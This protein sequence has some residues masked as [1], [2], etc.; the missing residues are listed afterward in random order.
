[1]STQRWLTLSALLATA[2]LAACIGTGTLGTPCGRGACPEPGD[3]GSAQGGD[4][5]PQGSDTAPLW[6]DA[7]A[8]GDTLAPSDGPA[9]A[10]IEIQ[11]ADASVAQGLSKGMTALRHEIDGSTS[12]V[13]ESCAWASSAPGTI[14]VGAAADPQPMQ[15][16]LPGVAT[17]TAT[18]GGLSGFTALTCVGIES[19]A[20]TPVSANLPQASSLQLAATADYGGSWTEDVTTIVTWSSSDTSKAAVDSGGEVTGIA[21]GVA[22]ITA[23]W[24]G[25][26][27]ASSITVTGGSSLTIDTTSPLATGTVGVAYSGPSFI[28]SGGSLPYTWSTTTGTLPAGLTLGGTGVISGT[29]TTPGIASFTV[30]VTDST[31]ANVS[32]SMS[33]E[34]FSASAT[35]TYYVSAAGS[36][37]WDGRTSSTPWA[38]LARVNSS[39]SSFVPADFIAFRRGDTFSGTLTLGKSGSDGLQ[40][41]F[42]AYGTGTNPVIDAGNVNARCI[43]TTARSYITIDGIDCRNAT[44]YG[45]GASSSPGSHIT[46]QNL[47]ISAI[48]TDNNERVGIYGI[49]GY[50]IIRNC[51]ITDISQNAIQFKG[52]HNLIVHNNISY[53][54]ARYTGWGAGI[55][56]DG[57]GDEL[58]YNVI[59]HCGGSGEINKTHGIYVQLTNAS[60][61]HNTITNSNRGAAIKTRGGGD[62]HHNYL[63]T[64]FRSGM[65]MGGNGA[66][67]VVLN[68]YSNIFTGNR[69]GI[70]VSEQD[71]G[72]FTV[73]VY[74][75]TFYRNDNTAADPYYSE[76][77]LNAD[78]NTSLVVKNNVF[79]GAGRYT[80]AFTVATT[81]T[82]IDYNCVYQPSG[83]LI[84]Y[85][86]SAITWAAWR[87]YGFDTNGFNVN[88]LFV[89]APA[90]LQLQPTSTCIDHG[91][92]MG[93]TEDYAGNPIDEFPDIGA[94]E[95]IPQ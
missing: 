8:D 2:T 43:S 92:D 86:G 85:G 17:I 48:G 18:C 75:N 46:I 35:P 25:E 16:I 42:G 45:I 50:S 93:L 15:G 1:M 33:L 32:K 21:A 80:Y 82:V 90:D 55:G 79:Y 91:V 88:P 19:L 28:A 66:I 87:G 3:T 36:D 26:Q 47:T 95:F 89:G 20:V 61:H 78:A 23:D 37:G 29:P 44:E 39:M 9:V 34:V 12:S 84:Y 57:D 65:E 67:V 62:F 73:N 53:T 60:V 41:T 74:N 24:L 30:K 72:A 22:T 69:E 7:A 59:D 54:N 56:G 58:A 6:G 51:T 64:S 38:T 52:G 63:S 76:F 68:I 10:T 71:S 94:Y 5:V 14:A 49:G 4:S 40:I 83:S 70:M 13:T 31:S 11:P 77:A 27:G 81:H